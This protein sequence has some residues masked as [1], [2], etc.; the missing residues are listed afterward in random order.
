MFASYSDLASIVMPVSGTFLWSPVCVAGGVGPVP[1]P[2][3]RRYF[4]TGEGF[5]FVA[6][7]VQSLLGEWE[8]GEPL[9][10]GGRLR[11]FFGGGFE[12]CR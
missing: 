1:R 11:L 3:G 7:P 4:G 10:G 12:I 9:G 8:R 2:S 6:T 5:V